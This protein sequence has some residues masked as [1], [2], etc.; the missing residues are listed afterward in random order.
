MILVIL[1]VIVGNP[2]SGYFFPTS[3]NCLHQFLLYWEHDPCY[4]YIWV[5]I[6]LS[7]GDFMEY[8]Y[9]SKMEMG[10]STLH[11]MRIA[12]MRITCDN[13]AKLLGKSLS[14]K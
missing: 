5:L 13:L 3:N 6:I 1:L 8:G 12:C 7:M 4:I 9:G 2:N 10:A 14:V 11:S